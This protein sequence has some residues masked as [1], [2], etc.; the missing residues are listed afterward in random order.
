MGSDRNMAAVK[1]ADS[2]GHMGINVV[3][4][5]LLGMVNRQDTGQ[6]TLPTVY[7]FEPAFVYV[8]GR[9]RRRSSS[10]RANNEP[11]CWTVSVVDIVTST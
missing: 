1:L 2:D 6:Q 9:R 8:R 11:G 3:Y 5:I 4:A 10:I 7:I